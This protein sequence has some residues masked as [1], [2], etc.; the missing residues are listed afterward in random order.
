MKVSKA[1]YVSLNARVKRLGDSDLSPLMAFWEKRM[2]EDNTRGV[3]HGLDRYGRPLKPVTYR[4]KGDARGVSGL[5]RSRF[6]GVG[7]SRSGL[8]NNLTSKEYRR[9]TGPPL[10]P[11]GMFSRVITHAHTGH[12]YLTTSVGGVA[13]NGPGWFACLVWVDVVSMKNVPFLRF[14]FEGLGQ[15]QR[16]LRGVRPEGLALMKHDARDYCEWLVKGLAHG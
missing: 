13:V 7:P 11:R 3:M 4:P 16:D 10:A 14:H 9:L 2:S 8:Y 5:Q 15:K 6:V 1:G 12:G